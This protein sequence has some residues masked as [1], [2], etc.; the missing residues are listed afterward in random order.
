MGPIIASSSLS[1]RFDTTPLLVAVFVRWGGEFPG[2]Q[3]PQP[4]FNWAGIIA[5]AAASAIALVSGKLA[6]GIIPINGIVSAFVVYALL[7]KLA[8]QLTGRLAANR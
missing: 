8:P 1:V 3:S 4:A 5:Y 6:W 7:V 2:L